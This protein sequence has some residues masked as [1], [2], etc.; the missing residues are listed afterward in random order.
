MKSGSKFKN[1]SDNMAC[2]YGLA[3]DVCIGA[4]GALLA[5]LLYVVVFAGCIRFFQVNDNAIPVTNEVAKVICMLLAAVIAVWKRP[6]RGWL[7]GG[8]AGGLYVIFS[9]LL[10]SIIDGNWS[11]SWPFL[12]DMVMGLLVG[13]IGGILLVNIR[14]KK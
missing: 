4:A 12:S 9:F 11:I 3:W 1:F 2:K 8:I 6:E 10:F 7:K 13:A 5:A 14:K